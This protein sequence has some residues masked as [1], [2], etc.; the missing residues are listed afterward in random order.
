MDARDQEPPDINTDPPPDRLPPDIYPD[1]ETPCTTDEDCVIV[2]LQNRC[3]SPDPIAVPRALA[4]SDPCWHELGQPW[5]NNP[6]CLDIECFWCP[7]I[8]RRAYGARCEG[9]VCVPV[10]DFCSPDEVPAPVASLQAL[11]V[12]PGGWEQYRGQVVQ[13]TG[14]PGLGPYSC[15][16]GEGCDDDCLD[17]EIQQML[18]C[19]I[20]LMGSVCGEPWECGGTE[21][22]PS[23][24][25]RLLSN[26][27][28][29]TGYLVDSEHDGFELWIMSWDNDCPPPGPNGEGEPCTPMGGDDC[30]EGLFCFYWGDVID[31]CIGTC[32]LPGD[33]CTIDT[34]CDDGEVCYHGY[35]MWCCPG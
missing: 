13:V 34:E 7:P 32:R 14:N 1:P 4:G 29:F 15:N 19:N 3:C 8:D 33:E 17:E 27:A 20:I 26:R 23:C 24:S 35:C 25:P 2:L 30:A 12:P 10:E 28:T 11:A 31:D 5:I 9:G 18:D 16:C 22:E 21:C 6:E